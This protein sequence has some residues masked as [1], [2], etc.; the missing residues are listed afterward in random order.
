MPPDPAP[1]P[2]VP[3]RAAHY[4]LAVLTLVSSFNYL[5]RNLFSIVLESIKAEMHLSDTALGLVGGFAFVM[6]Y[7]LL[8]VPIAW[9]ADRFNRRTII[10]VGLAFW[11]LM[12]ALTGLVQNVWQLAA[13]RFLMGAGEASSTAPSNSMLSDLYGRGRRP[14][15]LSI[16]SCGAGLGTLAGYMM[17]G[18]VDQHYGWR[19][20]FLIAG[21]PGLAVALLLFLTVQEPP[22]GGAEQRAAAVTSHS[23][24][25]TLRYLAG[26]RS[27]V[28]L[29]LGGCLMA[30]HLYAGIIWGPAFLMRVHGLSPAETG[31]YMGLIRGPLGLLGVLAGGA[32]AVRLGR[33]DER[34]RVWMPALA[35]MLAAPAEVLF[36]FGPS[37]QASIIGL[38]AATF[39][40]AMHLGPVYAAVL[41][42]ARVRM[43]AVATA[44]FMLFANLFGQTVGPLGVGWLNDV[45][46]GRYGDLAIRYSMLLEAAAALFA[47]LLFWMAA[48][49]IVTDAHRALD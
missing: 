1:A 33:R 5:D 45:L 39:L 46:S 18:W 9:L 25:E 41:G 34:W 22:R 20:V 42:A 31:S 35:C 13:T 15:V 14:L 4:T 30:V 44:T 2:A 19:A 27:Y 7:S 37:L 16:Y 26:A 23:F 8:G 43:R 47:G 3:A 32:A 48:R 17:G 29:V 28:W 12:T 10:G 6:F 21:A 36:L 38:G 11:S 49:H 24:R 40:T